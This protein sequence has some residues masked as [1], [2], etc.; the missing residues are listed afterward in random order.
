MRGHVI[1]LASSALLVARV[2]SQTSNVTTCAP[3]Y[4]WVRS[5]RMQNPNSINLTIF[6]RSTAR[7]RHLAWLRHFLK[8][9]AKDV[10]P[11]QVVP[12]FGSILTPFRSPRQRW[13]S[14]QYPTK[15]ITQGPLRPTRHF[16]D[17]VR[18]HILSF[19]PVVVAKTGNLSTGRTGPQIVLKVWLIL[20]SIDFQSV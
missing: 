20:Y 18:L 7:I 1:F 4:Q 17:V 2:A 14:T 10:S 3:S 8:V 9:C 5:W 19:L 15:P 11:H 12:N 13:R 16:V 6:R